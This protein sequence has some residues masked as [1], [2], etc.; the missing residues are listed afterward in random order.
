MKV[1][2]SKIPINTKNDN[3]LVKSYSGKNPWPLI[4]IF[5]LLSSL[6]WYLGNLYYKTQR[7]RIQSE[8]QNVLASIADLKINEIDAW[9]NERLKDV[10]I[11]VGNSITG[12]VLSSYLKNPDSKRK[13]EINES[14]NTR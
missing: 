8:K 6:V 11:I 13:Q 1:I 5:L 2:E 10:D 12:N 7:S 4:L 9:K 3:H 14:E